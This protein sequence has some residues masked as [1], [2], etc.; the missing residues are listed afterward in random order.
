[1]DWWEALNQ[2]EAEFEAAEHGLEEL[3]PNHA[4]E[5][6]DLFDGQDHH[7]PDK[8]D[9]AGPNA[10]DS[11]HGF[12]EEEQEVVFEFDD[13]DAAFVCK[14]KGEEAAG[15]SDLPP[16]GVVPS[17]TIKTTAAFLFLDQIG[18]TEVP[19]VQGVGMGVHLTTKCWQVR[20]PCGQGKKSA[21][22]CWGVLKKGYIPPCRA[23]LQCLLWCWEAHRKEHPHCTISAGK[24]QLLKGAI[25]ADVGRDVK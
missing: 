18:L 19:N 4:A 24:C 11:D 13:C 1:L 8:D 7:M 10:H 20:Y 23:L 3:I 25:L 16:V 12:S 2:E 9:H 6:T 22:R 21:G 15:S 14:G 17:G 5:E